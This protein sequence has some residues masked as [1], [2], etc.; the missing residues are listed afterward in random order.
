MSTLETATPTTS[1]ASVDRVWSGLEQKLEQWGE[2]LNPILVKEARQALK[3]KQFTITFSLLLIAAWMW[4]LLGIVSQL[5]DIY[6]A[7]SGLNLLLGYYFILAVPLLLIVPFSAFRSLACERED[8][9]YELL[10]ISTLSSRQIITGKLGSAI[11]QMIVY[12]SALA[13][14]IAF[15]YLLRGV[16]IVSVVLL[17]AYTFCLSVLLCCIGLVFAGISTSRQWQSLLS[18]LL[19][20]CLIGVG[21]FWAMMIGAIAFN[22]LSD[23]P[24][25][26]A[27][28]W[29]AQGAVFT[30]FASYVVLLILVAS[31]QNSF[32]SDN[33]ST[34]IRIAIFAQTVLFIGWL[35]Y[36]WVRFAEAE[37]LMIAI[38]FA[39]I[40]WYVY[41]VLMSGETQRCRRVCDGN[42]RC[43]FWGEYA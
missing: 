17:L 40:H 9:T 3:S 10:S 27:E 15:T 23:F 25:D 24:L 14:C 7:P 4:S 13:P 12:Y 36:A 11:L 30:A 34:R 42:C 20:L 43:R 33:R 16:D 32:A 31:A 19:L 2:R 6:Y 8:L 1:T 26:D 35:T 5:P 22:G 38:I 18:V 29:I 39:V 21:F 28:F 37:M 41:G